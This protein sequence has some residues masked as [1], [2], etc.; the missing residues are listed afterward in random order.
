MI[1]VGLLLALLLL[2]GLAT[3]QET[4]P[5]RPSMVGYV[6][7]ATVRTQFRFRFDAGFG[8]NAPDR[9]EFFYA[10]CGCFRSSESPFPDPE[11]PGPGPGALYSLDYQQLFLQGDWAVSPRLGLFG[12]VTFRSVNPKRF[13]E[14]TPPSDTFEGGTGLGDTRVGAKLALLLEEDRALTLQ[15]RAGIPTGDAGQGLG[16]D[17]VSLE[18]ALLFSN[19][20]GPRW[21]L[22]TQLGYHHPFGGSDPIPGT[23]ADRYAGGI[24]YY[25][26]GPSF[27]AWETERFLMTPVLEVVGWRVLDGNQAFCSDGECAFTVADPNIVNAKLGF[28]FLFGNTQSFYLGFGAALSDAAW[29]KSIL[30]TEYRHAL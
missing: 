8:A 21:G 7:D 9:A 11:A 12:E 28:R 23:D 16:N 15:I 4:T 30:R 3:A 6:E 26:I 27:D 5:R 20:L 2:P 24:L 14:G 25:G 13:V 22:E 10:K 29:Y 17:N 19:R 18:P 1:R